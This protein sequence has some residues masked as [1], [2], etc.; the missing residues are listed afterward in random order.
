MQQ[1]PLDRILTVYQEQHILW[2]MMREP[3]SDHVRAAVVLYLAM[4]RL[5]GFR[6]AAGL[7]AQ[8]L[9]QD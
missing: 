3:Q 8:Q 6:R 1:S 4:S 9:L 2:G 7:A 5:A